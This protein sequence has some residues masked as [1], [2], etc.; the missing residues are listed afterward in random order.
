[1][2]FIK[3]KYLNKRWIDTDAKSDPAS[4][5]WSDRK[6]FEKLKERYQSGASKQNEDD[7]EEEESSED[8]EERRRRRKERKEKKKAK[9][10]T[11]DKQ[12]QS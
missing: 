6:K 5:F 4:L 10:E 1:M 11:D 9:K 12:R 8:E 2:R 7:E 3:E